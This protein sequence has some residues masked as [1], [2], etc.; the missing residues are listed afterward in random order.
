MCVCGKCRHFTPDDDLG[1]LYGSCEVK[2]GRYVAFYA[3]CDLDKWV[4]KE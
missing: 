4:K 2:N 1:H 3:R